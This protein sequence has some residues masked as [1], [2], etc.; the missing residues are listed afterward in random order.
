MAEVCDCLNSEECGCGD[1]ICACGVVYGPDATWG[2][3]DKGIVGSLFWEVYFRDCMMGPDEVLVQHS[4]VEV[5]EEKVESDGVYVVTITVDEELK[6]QYPEALVD[7]DAKW[8]DL[9]KLDT[10][11]E[12]NIARDHRISIAW[13]PEILV[14]TF[15]LAK[16]SL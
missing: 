10:P 13:A 4:K 16:R 12:L 14:E 5:S 3:V 1:N 9:A 15:L 2:N 8:Y 6:S 7:I 11:L